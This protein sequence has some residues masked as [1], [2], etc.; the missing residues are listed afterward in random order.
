M[1]AAPSPTA[2]RPP[3]L[4]DIDWSPVARSVMWIPAE[5]RQGTLDEA[6]VTRI[7]R[8][9]PA[10]LAA[11]RD[12]G[13]T[14]QDTP[15]GPLYDACDI[16]NAALY[17]LSQRT[18]V[19]AAMRPILS[20]LRGAEKDLFAERRWN[21]RMAPAAASQNGDCLVSPL[22]PE[23]F[24]GETLE[25][26]VGDE[27]VVD[28]ARIAVPPGAQ[29][30]GTVVT[31]GRPDP[32]VS[33]TIRSVTEEFLAS[34][35]RWHYLAEGLKRDAHAAF[36]AGVGNCDTLSTVLAE[37]LEAH[38]YRTALYRGWIIGIT[39]VPHSWIEVVDDDERVKVIDP[40]LLLLA[41][42]SSI[43]SPDFAAKAFGG[44][45]SRIVPTRC[46]LAEP[47]GVLTTEAGT[48]RCDM[49]FT[50]RPA[51]AAPRETA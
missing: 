14:P 6:L 44:R 25:L 12:L 19:E 9:T 22:T 39:E 31:R 40:S 32:V 26:S 50:C 7:L 29:L 24:G 23:A 33:P 37:R 43:G 17:S 5:Y 27:P 20:F 16:R 36:A 3:V 13:L 11:L 15:E 47:I 48:I 4:Y 38:G 49:R 2:I 30:T 1:T 8:C 10:S 35:V 34:G 28:G 41:A 42:N 18:E 46:P 21:Y 45:L 51:P